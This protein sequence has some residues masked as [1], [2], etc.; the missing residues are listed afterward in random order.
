ME[1]NT[2]IKFEHEGEVTEGYVRGTILTP[3]TLQIQ[4]NKG[5]KNKLV[6]VTGYLVS[7]GY[8]SSTTKPI[9]LFP[10]DILEIIPECSQDS[11]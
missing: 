11:Y 7:C 1:R 5:L 3:R 4:T 10:E 8:Y 6:V 2:R 9:I